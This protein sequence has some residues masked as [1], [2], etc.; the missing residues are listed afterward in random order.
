MVKLPSFFSI[1]SFLVIELS[2]TAAPKNGI[3]KS[4]H[5]KYCLGNE[6]KIHNGS[7]Q[8]SSGTF[9]LDF[10]KLTAEGHKQCNLT[11]KLPLWVTAQM[12]VNTPREKGG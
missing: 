12:L 11:L 8:R 3:Y 5:D 1:T 2:N 7:I 10:Q 6:E 9:L 4:Q